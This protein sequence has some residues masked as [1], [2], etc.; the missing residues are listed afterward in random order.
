MEK[1][2]QGVGIGKGDFTTS[3][4]KFL[5]FS[6]LHNHRCRILCGLALHEKS[7]QGVAG[8]KGGL[9]TLKPKLFQFLRFA[10]NTKGGTGHFCLYRHRF[11]S[12][13]T[14]T[15]T[16]PTAAGLPRSQTSGVVCSKGLG[17][18]PTSRNSDF[19]QRREP[20]F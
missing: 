13:K 9:D 4:S 15:G 20:L 8:E 6:D 10:Q 17:C 11:K 2:P 19:R 7:S 5:I 12:E 1:V 16:S 18:F 3:K 14:K